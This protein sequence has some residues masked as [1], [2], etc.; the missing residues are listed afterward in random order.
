MGSTFAPRG[1]VAIAVLFAVGTGCGSSFGGCGTLK[2]LPA[3]LTPFGVPNSQVIE[4]GVHARLTA[5]GL[6]KFSV[7]I[8][9]LLH[10]QL[11]THCLPAG[12]PPAH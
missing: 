1:I 12:C 8:E 2:P 9:N 5:P 11:N 7:V 6:K 10:S 4:G 3:G